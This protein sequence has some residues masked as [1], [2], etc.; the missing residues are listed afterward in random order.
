MQMARAER[1]DPLAQHRVS[2]STGVAQYRA[3]ELVDETV[4]AADEALYRA[5]MTGRNRVEVESA[6]GG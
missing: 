4:R 2:V 1:P 3:V 6:P 5:K